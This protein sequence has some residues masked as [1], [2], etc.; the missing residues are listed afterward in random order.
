MRT[1]YVGYTINHFDG[2]N[3]TYTLEVSRVGFTISRMTRLDGGSYLNEGDLGPFET[4]EEA[5]GYMKGR[6]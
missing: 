4:E 2:G 1:D 3:T 5:R 6:K